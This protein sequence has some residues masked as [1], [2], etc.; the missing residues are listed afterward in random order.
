VIEPEPLQQVDRTYVLYRGRKLSYFAGCDYFRLSSHPSVIITFKAAAKQSGL[1]VAAS[2]LTTGNHVLFAKLERE[3]ARFFAS[4][5][6]LLV[7]SGY[8]ANLIVAQALAGNFSHA[9]LDEKAHPSLCDAARFLDCPIVTF[10]HRDA[11]DLARAVNRCGHMAQMILLTDGLFAHSGSVA[12]IRKYLE[13]LPADAMLLVDDAHAA[14]ILGKGGRGSLEFAGVSRHRAIQTITLSKAFGGYGGAILGPANLRQRVLKHSRIFAGSTPLPLPFVSASLK[15]IA[16]L[17]DA[18]LRQRLFQN[19]S[20]VRNTL[21]SSGFGLPEV[22]GPMFALHYEQQGVVSRL[23]RALLSGGIYPPFIRYPGGPPGGYF[24]FVISNQHTREQ[25][26]QLLE[27]L[28]SQ[29]SFA[30]VRALEHHFQ[31]STAHSNLMAVTPGA[32]ED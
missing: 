15:A 9:L 28:L 29:S 11:V 24:R 21:N 25:L 23:R 13:I 5:E 3:L 8:V 7:S 16:L 2:R 32:T 1:S 27:A 31:C 22:P 6:A 18:S 12:P 4:R 30:S 26:M 10:K 17:K 20:F 19:V 14:G